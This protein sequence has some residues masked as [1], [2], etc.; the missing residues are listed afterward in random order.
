[1]CQD[2]G[3]FRAVLSFLLTQEEK[4]GFQPFKSLYLCV[5]QQKK[6]ELLEKNQ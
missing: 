3:S 4:K 1:M 6:K 2:R 5:G